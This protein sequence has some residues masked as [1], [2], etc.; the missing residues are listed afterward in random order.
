[1]IYRT[2]VWILQILVARNDSKAIIFLSNLI[3][4]IDIQGID[5]SI[6]YF[7][8]DIH[9]TKFLFHK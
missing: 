3:K 8:F 9:N 1:M 6:L 4:S 2:I 7:Y 5:L